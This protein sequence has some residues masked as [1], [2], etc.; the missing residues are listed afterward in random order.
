M[1]NPSI[2]SDADLIYLEHAQEV[3]RWRE[4]PD[5]P[6]IDDADFDM[7]H[8]V[9]YH[10]SPDEQAIYTELHQRFSDATSPDDQLLIAREIL[11][12]L[13]RLI[14]QQGTKADPFI[15]GTCPDYSGEDPLCM[16]SA[17]DMTEP[18]PA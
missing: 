2:L 8:L 4:L 9:K 6:L 10:L 12:W 14:D 11:V 17:A 1:R 15:Q 5:Q 3:I 16:H 13:I 18:I 7:R